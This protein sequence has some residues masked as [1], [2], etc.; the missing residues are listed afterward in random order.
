M[1]TG[2]K[3][4]LLIL[5]A[6]SISCARVVM[7]PG[8]PADTAPPQIKESFP[9]N[10]STQF[11]SDKIVINF[12][13][14]VVLKSFN[15]EFV[16][17]P[18][19]NEKPDKVL[20]GKSLVLKFDKDS[21]RPNTTYTLDFGNSIVDFHAGNILRDFQY[22]FSTGE[23]ID[24][25]KISGHLLAAENLK[26]EEKVWVMLYKDFNDSIFRTQKPDFIAK[27]DKDGFYSINNI[28]A[29]TYS[30]FALKD[31]NNNFIF[32]LPNE[33]IAFL[34]S[35][36]ILTIKE[37]IT[38]S[39]VNKKD[40]LIVINQ[41]DTTVFASNS[42]LTDTIIAKPKSIIS[43]DHIDLFLFEEEFVNS[44]LSDF[45]RPKRYLLNLIFSNPQDSLLTFNIDGANNDEWIIEPNLVKDTFNIWLIDTVLSNQDSIIMFVDYLKT[46]STQSLIQ[47]RDTLAFN[48]KN[49]LKFKT[50]KQLKADKKDSLKINKV[51]LSM[52][53]NFQ[54]QNPLAFFKKPTLTFGFPLDSVD[55]SKIFFYQ[56]VDTIFIPQKIVLTKDAIN[57]RKYLIDQVLKEG[58]EYKV[59]IEPNAFVDYRGL[60]NDTLEQVFKTTKLEKYT[61]IL[62]NIK[63]VDSNQVI[64]QLFSASE[65]MVAEQIVNSDTKLTFEHLTPGK[66]KIKLIEDSNRNGQWDT[67]NYQLLRQAEEVRYYKDII[68]TK[69]NWSHDIV[70][71][72]KE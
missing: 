5:I 66:Y 33:Q 26:P 47:T 64:I 18:L 1:M 12:D 45:S 49:K 54:K 48:F 16:S 9:T 40:T 7:P 71:N 4:I 51:Y 29:G 70:W 14:Y 35:V 32:D 43:P 21:L 63:G 44:Y 46:D 60:Y 23:L 61:E 22:V 42:I 19:F 65:K 62:L 28:A 34:D 50:K 6:L 52:S 20:K 59:F 58:S 30:M 67:G 17:S 11:Y 36:F 72:L 57:D 53:A 24:S 39:L 68:E 41:T 25:L 56:K 13:E 27:T 8:G 3:F 10:Y 31:I 69:P 2:S 55:Y 15:E 37:E 38:D